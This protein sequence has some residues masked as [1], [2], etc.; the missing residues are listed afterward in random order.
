MIKVYEGERA[1]TKDNNLLGKFEL[2]GIPPARRGVPQIEVTFG[3]D[4]NGILKVS[5]QDKG[6]GRK[7]SVTIKNDS[8]RLSKAEIERMIAEAEKF[9]DEDKEARERIGARD[10]L[11]NY[12]FNL[13]NQLEDQ[14]GLGAK[15]D[16]HEKEAVSCSLGVHISS[17]REHAAYLPL[18]LL[19]YR[20]AP[21]CHRRS[22][23]LAQ[24]QFGDGH[25][26]GLRGAEGKAVQCGLSN[27]HQT[28]RRRFRKGQR[29]GPSP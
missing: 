27:H 1:L 13:R 8:G 19:P 28:L 17:S 23:K 24:R 5:A 7:E 21:G 12:A 29:R 11:E 26:R 15:I 18:L 14:D 9:A 2:R 25:G 20:V 4:A 10:K 22:D 3:L 6:T 16:D